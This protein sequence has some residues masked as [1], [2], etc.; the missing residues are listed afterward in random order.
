M[1]RSKGKDIRTPLE[2][3]QLF[4]ERVEQLNSTRLIQSQG[5]SNVTFKIRGEQKP[6]GFQMTFETENPPDEDD[7]RSFL[8]SFRLF[9]ADKEPTF[10]N[11][12]FN[13]CEQHL[14][15]ERLKGEL[16][17]ARS[18]WQSIMQGINGVGIEVDG[19]ILDGEYVLDL[20]INGHY[21]HNEY[22]HA[23][24]LK[25]L[26]STQIRLDRMAFVMTISDA[27]NVIFYVGTVVAYGLKNG[28]FSSLT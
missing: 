15:D 19:K 4:V 14:S 10:I 24:E 26:A 21:F 23:Q 27:T 20:W 8:L 16:R 2:Q 5:L 1:V 9:I 3:L 13:I 22:E 28:L 12:I 17:K 18:N 7:L 25:R 11:K 6:E